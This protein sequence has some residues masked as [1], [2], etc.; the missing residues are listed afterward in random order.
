[1]AVDAVVE[2]GEVLLHR[3]PVEVDGIEAQA[4]VP[5]QVDRGDRRRFRD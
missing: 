2:A 4:L 3:G 1:M 5:L